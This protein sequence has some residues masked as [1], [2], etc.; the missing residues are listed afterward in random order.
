MA[1]IGYFAKCGRTM[2]DQRFYREVR[3][4]FVSLTKFRRYVLFISSV[5]TPAI[6]GILGTVSGF[7]PE[8]KSYI[9][10]MQIAVL[11]FGFLLGCGLFWFDEHPALVF[12]KFAHET[13]KNSELQNEIDRQR[14]ELVQLS[15][16]LSCLSVAARA[17]ESAL[18]FAAPMRSSLEELAKQLLETIADQRAQLFGIRDE[19]Q[20]N[21]AIYLQ[22]GGQLTCLFHRRNFGSPG[23]SARA[24][25]IGSGHV[26]LAYQREGELVNDDVAAEEVFQGKGELNR[27]YD[28]MRYRGTASICIPDVKMVS[29]PLAFWS[30][31]AVGWDVIPRQMLNRLEIWPNR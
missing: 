11:A 6:L 25:P 14:I 28:K 27:D 29:R 5:A 16:H 7:S 20:W 15:A 17:V 3:N 8:L 21:F 1:R 19:E 2:S 18:L 22:D 31:Q 23:D 10:P 9:V 4:W 30:Q 13:Q 12:Q 24:W 26:G